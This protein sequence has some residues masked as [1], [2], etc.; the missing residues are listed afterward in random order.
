MLMP[1]CKPC[2]INSGR[3]ARNESRNATWAAR[4][5][6][7]C[8]VEKPHVTR[9]VCEAGTSQAHHARHARSWSHGDPRVDRS[10]SAFLAQRVHRV[11]QYL[12]LDDESSQRLT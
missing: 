6:G 5:K 7:L 11:E 12:L 10:G 3:T 2:G 4:W 9:L 8:L 1:Q